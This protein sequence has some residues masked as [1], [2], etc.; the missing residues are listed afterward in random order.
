MKTTKVD[1]VKIVSLFLVI[2]VLVL[3]FLPIC[4]YESFTGEFEPVTRK[5]IYVTTYKPFYSI[6][7][8]FSRDIL[9]IGPFLM[10]FSFFGFYIASIVAL[11]FLLFSKDKLFLAFLGVATVCMTPYIFLLLYISLFALITVLAY[12]VVFIINVADKKIKSSNA[13]EKEEEHKRHTNKIIA[14]NIRAKRKSLYLT[15]EQL[16]EKSFLSRSL[17]S[18]IESAKVYISDD[19]L[20]R[21]SQA[22][23]VDN[24]E[25]LKQD[26][27]NDETHGKDDNKND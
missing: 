15:Q 3:S 1:Y 20:L 12:I 9:M 17:I 23:G 26:G 21:I 22:L 11:V 13:I 18:K 14:N 16:A 24:I 6:L 25:S 5:A 2:V 7:T 27:V 19:H 10:V 8:K 4:P